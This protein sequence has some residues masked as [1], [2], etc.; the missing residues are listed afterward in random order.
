M[1]SSTQSSDEMTLYLTVEQAAAQLQIGRS[2]AYRLAHEYESTNGASGMPVKRIGRLLR[3]CR[4]DLEAWSHTPPAHSN[5]V[6]TT[7][8]TATRS[9]ITS[10]VSKVGARRHAST[11]EQPALPFS[12]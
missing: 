6:D 9:S 10:P 1:R 5:V 3:V 12:A 8:S 7:P 2:L 11:V 4:T